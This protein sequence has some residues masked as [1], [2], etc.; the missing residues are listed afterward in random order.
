MSVTL[1]ESLWLGKPLAG[2]TSPVW[3]G[4]PQVRHLRLETSH[5]RIAQLPHG[6]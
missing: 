5:D 2:L 6:G 3:Q 4:Y 1:L